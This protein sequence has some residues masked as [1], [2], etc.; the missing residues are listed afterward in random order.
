MTVPEAA[1][2]LDPLGIPWW[3]S[4]GVALEAFHGV[5]RPHDDLD[6]GVFRRDLPI[7]RA[8]LGQRFHLWSV[9][10]GML[11]PITPET[12]DPHPESDQVWLREHALA[13]WRLDMLLNPDRD[14]AWVFRREPSFVAPLADVTWRSDGVRY[15]RPEIAL[16]FKAKRTRAKDDA[17]F[18]AA[19]PRLDAPAVAWLAAFLDRAAPGHP[20]RERLGRR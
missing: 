11:R 9:G 12:P 13:P 6:V 18:A 15:L 10:S 8:A 16:A 1:A 20:W 2:L 14:G 5:P 19:L 17:D 4:S 3:V 7:L